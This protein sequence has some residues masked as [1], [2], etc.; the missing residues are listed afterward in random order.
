[1]RRILVP[2]D[3]SNQQADAVGFAT[4]LMRQH[5]AELVGLCIGEEESVRKDAAEIFSEA[6]KKLN[7]DFETKI[8][9]EHRIRSILRES[10]HADLLLV[11]PRMHADED[12]DQ[13]PSHFVKELLSG[14]ECPV[15]LT[16]DEHVNIE[17]VVFSY[18]GSRSAMYAIKQFAYI[19][20][21]YREHKIE[22]L[23]VAGHE[24]AVVTGPDEDLM[25]WLNSHYADVHYELLRGRASEALFGH[26][27]RKKN[28][29]VTLGA[30][31][32]SVLSNF[33]RRST[34]NLLM[35]TAD[36]PLFITYNR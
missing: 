9:P 8:L 2:I 12:E 34:A 13:L 25:K 22:L 28:H 17:E 30:Y 33:F 6:C 15:V 11:D 27:R 36:I 32:R 19:L 20:P 10:R 16:P 18:D 26:F 35:R 1:M 4:Q 24:Q 29:L 5:E 7:L 14:S 23:Q 21:Q 31:G 3:P